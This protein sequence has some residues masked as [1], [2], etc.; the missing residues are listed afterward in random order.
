MNLG[1]QVKFTDINENINMCSNDLLRK[2]DK[3]TKIIMPVHMCGLS[4]NHKD[5]FKIAKR[6]KKIVIEDAAHSL[7]GYYDLDRKEKI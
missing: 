5:I 3:N 7:G 4:S 1:S 6:F 2:I